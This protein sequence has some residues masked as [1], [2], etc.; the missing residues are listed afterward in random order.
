MIDKNIL[1]P[2]FKTIDKVVFGIEESKEPETKPEFIEIDS[3]EEF[4]V[5]RSMN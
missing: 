1:A 5:E 3:E 4:D 2:L